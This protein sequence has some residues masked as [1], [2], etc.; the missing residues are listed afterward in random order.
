MDISVIIPTFNR[1]RLLIQ[2]IKSVQN[3]TYKP[4]EIIVVDDGSTDETK[5]LVK[6]LPIKY[7]FQEN[8]GV[9][10]ARNSGIQQAQSDWIAFLDSDDIWDIEKLAHHKSFNEN[11]SKLLCS[12]TDEK[13]IRNDKEIQPKAHLQKEN[14]TFE[15][16]LRTCK[17][18]TSTFFTHKSLFEDIG[19]FD[20]SLSAC[21][22]Y[23]MWLRILRNH[24]IAYIDK[25]LTTKYAGHEN[26]LSFTT[27]LIDT[28]RIDA[29]KKHL[30]SHFSKEVKEELL[31][32]LDILKKGAIKRENQAIIEYCNKKLQSVS[33]L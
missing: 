5:K 11:S 12:F 32:K 22:D 25:K 4:K 9:S 20:E 26:Q 23:D 27:P 7:I 1:A 2:A 10:S 6:N 29:L 31:F 17:I 18:G 15:N 30:N 13:W 16:S 14:P 24:K 33:N 21:E 19:Y 28:Y 8:R 3:Q